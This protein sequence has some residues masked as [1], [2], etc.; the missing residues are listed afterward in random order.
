MNLRGTQ[1]KNC[2]TAKVDY[3]DRVHSDQTV[4][5][6]VRWGRLDRMSVAK[7]NAKEAIRLK[8][9]QIRCIS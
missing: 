5:I 8:S 2:K 7:G 4:L 1:G 9:T 6:I 3:H